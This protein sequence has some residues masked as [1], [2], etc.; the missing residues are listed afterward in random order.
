MSRLAGAASGSQL[1]KGSA[2]SSLKVK[3]PG[4]LAGALELVNDRSF[5]GNAPPLYF[6]GTHASQP[7]I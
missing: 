6:S 1:A 4:P 5:S 2:F 7:P 3:T